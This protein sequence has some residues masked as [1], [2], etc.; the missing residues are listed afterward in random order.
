MKKIIAII[1]A[2]SSLALAQGD[3][4]AV[5]KPNGD[6]VTCYAKDASGASL[7]LSSPNATSSVNIYT[8]GTKRESVDGNGSKSFNLAVPTLAAT[9]NP[10]PGTNTCY[11][12]LC[13][14]PTAAANAAYLLPPITRVGMVSDHINT[15][16]NT[17][18]I[19]PSGTNTITSGGVAGS[20]G[21]YV[22][23]TTGQLGKCVATTTTNWHCAVYGTGP[24]PA[25]P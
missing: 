16:P 9:P 25:G 22:V 13:A 6:S 17:V 21:A 1:L 15:G 18:R 12:T 7:N 4:G 23:L 14:A 11:G 20:A 5:C 19:K 24:T 3:P 2:I 10:T 8:G